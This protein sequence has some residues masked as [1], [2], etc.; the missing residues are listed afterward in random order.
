MYKKGGLVSR[1]SSETTSVSRE[2]VHKRFEQTFLRSLLAGSPAYQCSTPLQIEALRRVSTAVHSKDIDEPMPMKRG[3]K[4][5]RVVRG[6]G[7]EY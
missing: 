1:F 7:S 6:P 3:H 5:T 2:Q 4:N